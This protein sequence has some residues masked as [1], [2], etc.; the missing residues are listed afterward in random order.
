MKAKSKKVLKIVAIVLAALI[1][2]GAIATGIYFGVQ[3]ERC[4]GYVRDA[5]GAPMEGVSVTNGRQVVKTDENGRYVLDGWLKDRFVTITIPSGYW[6]EDYYLEIGSAREGYDFTLEKLDEELTDHTFLQVSDSEVGEDGV[7]DW[8]ENVKEAAVDSGAAFIMHTGDICYEA[9]L[10]SHIN[11]MNSENMG[12]PVRY[13]I[14]NHDYVKWGNYAEDLYESTYGPVCYSFEV[15]NVHY[16]VTPIVH[17]ADYLGR[18]TNAD[19][20]RWVKND[21]E[22]T[23]PDKK[24]VMFNH[25]YCTSDEDGFVVSYGAGKKLDLKEHGLIVWIYGHWHYDLIYKTDCGVFNICTGQPQGGGIDSTLPAVRSVSIE[26][27]ELVASHMYYYDFDGAEPQEGC[28][29]TVNIGGE[30]QFAEPIVSG[31]YVYAATADDGWP[32]ECAISKVNAKTGEIVWT[33]ATDNSV[34]NS[35]FLTESGKL[36]A[37]DITGKVYCLDT[38]KQ[39]VEGKI[40]ADWVSDTRLAAVR[41]T[42]LNVI[43]DGEKVY[44]GGAQKSVCLSLSSGA[45][46][47]ET[48]ND[49]ANS[50]PT[51][52]IVS[53]D[54]LYVGSHWDE[55]IAYD[56]N[57][58]KRVW[59][60][61]GDGIR[62]R[63]STPFM[64]EGGL[65]VTTSASILELD[66]Q[67][68]K[69]RR[70]TEIEGVNLDTAAIPLVLDGTVYMGTADSGVVAI[71][72]KTLKLEWK[73][74]E[75]G[76]ALVSSTPYTKPGSRQVQSG[77]VELNDYLYFGG[78]DGAV[79]KLSRQG[80]L[81]GKIN[82]G[83]PVMSAPAVYQG[84]LIVLDLSGNLSKITL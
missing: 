34:R 17:G 19:V 13:A 49:R 72:L 75:V 63:T 58:G 64:F 1:V 37:Q 22:N 78:M 21:L 29:W 23:S 15:G 66:P 41:N 50:S 31:D 28:D 40:T 48:E 35:M 57:T 24:V 16:I 3:S 82:L 14:G 4:S 6:T 45:L 46:V 70:S 67:S 81:E 26:G 8:I 39:A 7:G 69:V 59:S 38:N 61:D 77:V 71:D 30:G 65:Y 10:K 84:S 68:G 9:G 20:W 55:L 44:C 12:V 83:S 52:M 25:D 80:T 60:N 56:K 54:L 62:Y 51:R 76:G 47:W 43:A 5:E 42:G 18:Y 79:Y 33:Y 11:G 27:G 36:L 74:E 32:K 73:F 53:G 2:A